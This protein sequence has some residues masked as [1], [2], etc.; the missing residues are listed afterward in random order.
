MWANTRPENAFFR[1]E[2]FAATP[3]Q[4]FVAH[5]TPEMTLPTGKTQAPYWI[6]QVRPVMHVPAV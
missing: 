3:D 4:A 2:D 6:W 5:P 1:E